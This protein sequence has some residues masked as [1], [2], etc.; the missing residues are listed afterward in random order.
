MKALAYLIF[1]Q[2][3]NRILNLRKKPALLIFYCLIFVIAVVS[4]I[5][6][7]L[8]P[9]STSSMAVADGRVIYLFIGGFGL[10]YI[11]TFTYTGLATGSTFFNMADVGLL[12]VAP[13]SPIKVLIY[14]LL[15]AI[16]KAMLASLFILYQIPNLRNMLG[17]GLKEILSLF[18]IYMI[19]VIFNQLLSIG[20]YIYTNGNESRKNLV[21]S[22]I[23]GYLAAVAIIAFIMIRKEQTGILEALYRMTESKWF[24]FMPVAGWAIMFFKGVLTGSAADIVISLGLF[25]LV[26]AIFIVMLTGRDTDYYED[27]LYSTEAAYQKLMYAKGERN[28]TTVSTNV[29]R[30]IK[31]SDNDHGIKKGKG[32]SVFMYKHLL[33]MK[34]SSNFI[35]IDGYTIFATIGAG[36]AGYFLHDAQKSYII[37]IVL[38]YIQYFFT[39]FGRLSIELIKPYI[40]LIPEP[41]FKKLIAASASSL[42]KPC[43]DAVLIFGVLGVTQGSGLLQCIFMALAYAASGTVFVGLTVVYQRLF[44]GQPNV[45]ARLFV[46]ILLLGAV[47]APGVVA[48]LMVEKL[49]LPDSMRFMA[50]LPYTVI[51]LIAAFIMFYACRNLLDNS[52]YSGKLM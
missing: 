15:S 29:N 22:F 28:V 2:L 7:F 31:I 18:F 25:I 42:L 43:V 37:M 11:Y 21:K 41:S 46:S 17:Y 35:F 3:K 14:G 13:I 40:Y 47:I 27:V 48:S 12:F 1:T 9:Q 51:C 39:L 30:K 49:W 26:G 50:T 44:G 23:Y 36:I 33:E 8:V 24:G 38:I 16:G 32:A 19:L 52:E 20:V 5:A 10:L 34:R 4:I 45:V 6:L